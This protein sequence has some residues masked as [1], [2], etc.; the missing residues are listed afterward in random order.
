MNYFS[1]EIE[2]PTILIMDTI[3]IYM[4]RSDFSE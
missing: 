2:I 3:R 4:W 1:N